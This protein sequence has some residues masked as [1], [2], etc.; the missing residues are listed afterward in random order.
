MLAQMKN[1]RDIPTSQGGTN[2][3]GDTQ[4]SPDDSVFDTLV[5]VD[6]NLDNMFGQN[7]KTDYLA[8][9]KLPIWG[10]GQSY[11]K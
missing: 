8:E 7:K 6:G 11:V 5:D 3:A 4:A 10:K 1:V 2:N 9:R